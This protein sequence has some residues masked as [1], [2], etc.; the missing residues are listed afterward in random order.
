MTTFNIDDELA[1]ITPSNV[2]PQTV[3]Q[4]AP[5]P[6]PQ[7]Q[8]QAPPPA[9][10]AQQ[11]RA[12]AAAIEDDIPTGSRSVS[13]KPQNADTLVGEE[14]DWGDQELMKRGDGLDRIR[15]EKKSGRVVRFSL[16]DFIP[17][18]WSGPSRMAHNHY[19]QTLQ[20]KTCRICLSTKEVT[21][22]CCRQIGEDGQPHV[23][24]LALEYTNANPKDGGYAPLADGT[25]PPI[26]WKIK[27]VDLSR[28]N[29]QTIS[30][31][32][33][34]GNNCQHPK[35]IQAN[36]T[37]IYNHDFV[38]GQNGNK[39]EFAVKARKARWKTNPALVAAVTAAAQKYLTDGGIRL[40]KKLGRKTSLIEWKALLAS[41]AAGAAEANLDNIE[42]L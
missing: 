34:E 38:M 40:A 15:P 31:L 9:Q 12:A 19:V 4:A 35:C 29:F 2:K 32:V 8:A 10:Q 39:Y 36:R 13:A 25:L 14:V 20:G 3:P 41:L 22:Y 33:E 37:C 28:A 18:G 17:V 7:P 5:A 16:L 11:V 30:T 27:Y 26:E 6:Q 23:V 21:G 1:D 42:N 24:N